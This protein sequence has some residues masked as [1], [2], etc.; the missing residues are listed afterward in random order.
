MEKEGRLGSVDHSI[1]SA[2]RNSIQWDD[3]EF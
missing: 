1:G 2:G 3:H